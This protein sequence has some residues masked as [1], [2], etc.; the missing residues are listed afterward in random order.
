M[1][2]FPYLPHSLLVKQLLYRLAEKSMMVLVSVE[3]VTSSCT[4]NES[5]VIKHTFIEA[6]S[7]LFM[8][9]CLSGFRF[10]GSD[11]NALLSNYILSA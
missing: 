1:S 6:T 7:C 10:R 8:V 9:S 4:V 5:L 3:K 2:S 11:G